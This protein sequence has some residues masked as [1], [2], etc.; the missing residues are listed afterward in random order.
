MTPT[1]LDEISRAISGAS[2]ETFRISS[3]VDAAGG[4]INR[5]LS[6]S[7]VDGRRFFV[8]LNQAAQLS[9]FEAEAAGL[10]ELIGAQAIR[11]PRPLTH[12]LA[13]DESFLVMEWLEL[14]RHGSGRQLG[15]QLARLH[16]N[17]HQAFGWWRDNTIG[18]TQQANT[19]TDDWI[20]FYREQRLRPQFDLAALNGAGKTFIDR[21]ERLLADLAAFFPGYTPQPSLL[22]GDLWSG[23][24]AYCAG[25]PVIFDPAVYYGDRE[26]DLAMAEL[27]GGFPDDFY[28]AYDSSW[29]LDPGYAS[30]KLLYQLYHL[31]NHFNLFGGGYGRQ[32]QSA[33]DRLLAEAG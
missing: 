10:A 29:P 15:E 16:R 8:K 6:L 19:E 7:G 27:F 30:R 21:G 18:S 33:L 26:T 31:L 11:V 13:G 28:R 3:H 25:M 5:G 20:D 14:S 1:L 24:V 17:T 4:C 32:A 22:H 12:G 2:G 23:N 9:M